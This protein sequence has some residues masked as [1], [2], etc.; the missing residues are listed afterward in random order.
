MSGSKRGVRM[1]GEGVREAGL[2]AGQACRLDHE[3][4]GSWKHRKSQDLE[5]MHELIMVEY[6]KMGNFVK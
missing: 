4:G 2:Q 1:T 5:Y 6:G 3:R